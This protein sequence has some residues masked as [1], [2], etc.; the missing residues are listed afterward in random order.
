[1]RAAAVVTI[2]FENRTIIADFVTIDDSPEPAKDAFSK[3]F[4]RRREEP[5]LEHFLVL[6]AE[7]QAATKMR[8]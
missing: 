8:V 1:M 4:Y 7:E 3:L 6:N 5:T 2:D